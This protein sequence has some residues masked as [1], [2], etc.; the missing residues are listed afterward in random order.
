MIKSF[1]PILCIDPD[2]TPDETRYRNSCYRFFQ[3]DLKSHDDAQLHCMQ[4]HGHLVYIGSFE[5]QLFL[6]N[7]ATI[8]RNGSRYYNNDNYWIGLT[9][10]L[11]LT[12]QDGR[13]LQ[14][15]LVPEFPKEQGCFYLSG[16]ELELKVGNCEMTSRFICEKVTSEGKEAIVGK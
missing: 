6:Q 5:E 3:N 4:R 13:P 14:P 2:C 11:K 7:V 9:S 10:T 15:G 8:L 12:W 16:E 1:F